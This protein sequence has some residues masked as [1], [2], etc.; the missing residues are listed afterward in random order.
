MSFEGRRLMSMRRAFCVGVGLGLFACG[1]SVTRS[2]EPTTAK[3]SEVAAHPC[4]RAHAQKIPVPVSTNRTG[5][6]LALAARDATTIAYVADED[7]AT[8]YTVDAGS[9]KELAATPLRGKPS[10]LL[11]HSD[12]RVFVAIA[13]GAQ[14]EVLEPGTNLAEPLEHRC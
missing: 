13:G 3:P 12:G 8:L 4:A 2:N 7:T 6:A 14:V 9:L 11:L 5:N 10:Q 1:G